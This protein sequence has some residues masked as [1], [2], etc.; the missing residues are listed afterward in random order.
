MGRSLESRIAALEGPS[1]PGVALVL[2]EDGETPEDAADRWSRE[3][4]ETADPL[5]VVETDVDELPEHDPFWR[6]N[7]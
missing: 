2:V 4:A 6:P 7:R 3:H 1:L 5:I